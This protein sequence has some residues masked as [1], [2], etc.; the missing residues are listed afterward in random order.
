LE[1]RTL[2]SPEKIGNVQIKNRIVRSAT[3]MGSAEKYGYVNKKLIDIYSELARGG[4]GLIISG[5]TAVDPGGAASPYQA[6]L[7][8]DS[9]IPSQKNL[10]ETVHQYPDVKIAVQIAHTGRQ[11]YHPKYHPVAPS[12]IPFKTTGLTPRE[13]ASEEIEELIQKFIDAGCRAY[14]CG[15]DLIQLHAAH[16]YFLSNFISPY[17][18]KRTDD[19]GGNTQKRL[20]ILIDIYNGLKDELGKN[21]P[22][23][24][25]LQVQDFIPDG[26]TLEEGVEYAKILS[27][28]GY[29][30]IEPSG[31]GGDAQFLTKKAYPSLHIKTPEEENYFLPHVKKIKPYMKKSKLFLMGGIK[32]PIFAEKALQENYADFISM[33]RPLIYEPN[34]PNRWKEGDISPAKCISCN[35]CYMTMRVGPVYCVTKKRL[36]KR[37][38]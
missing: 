8:D 31:G 4:T 9:F 10:V 6:C 29:D 33:S 5:F 32:N 23:T 27:E 11:G 16:G 3:F 7:Y 28:I 36:E 26:L 19:Y 13:L 25:K 12:P 1:L 14:T 22:V 30:A 20:K 21:Y 35:G 34:L 15:Y 37:K 38:K 17:T 18:N 2:F 24:V